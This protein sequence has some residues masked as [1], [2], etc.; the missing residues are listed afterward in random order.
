VHGFDGGN[1]LEPVVPHR[2]G[3]RSIS[4]GLFEDGVHDQHGH[5][6]AHPVTLIGNAGQSFSRD[7]SQCRFEGVQLQHIRP[8]QKVGVAAT[9]EAAAGHFNAGSGASQLL[10]IGRDEILGMLGDPGVIGCDVV[11][12]EIEDK[13]HAALCQFAA[14]DRQRLRP[15]QVGVDHV[16]TH[17]TGRTH[18]IL[19]RE[20]G[21]SPPK[22]LLQAGIGVG[23][24]D[25]RGTALPYPHE[26]HRVEAQTRDVVPHRFRNRSEGQG[27]LSFA[28]EL[29]QPHPGVDFINH[30]VFRPAVH[31]SL[32]I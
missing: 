26:P 15:S 20:I 10:L 16:A 11:G 30:R 7:D 1:D 25:P 14:G 21:Q 4:P 31:S 27:R 19:L 17:A 5:V 32:P 29:S 28:A 23:D 22:V 9:G 13:A 24:A 12:Y 3:A 6:A 8:G 18:V 2:A